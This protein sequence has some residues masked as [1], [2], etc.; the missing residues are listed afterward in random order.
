MRDKLI[1]TIDCQCI[2]CQIIRTEGKKITSCSKSFR[3]KR[4]RWHFY[5]HPVFDLFVECLTG[6]AEITFCRFKMNK[7]SLKFINGRNH[8]E[9]DLYIAVCRSSQDSTQLTFKSIRLIKK[10]TDSSPS[11]EWVF[12]TKSATN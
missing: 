10:I 1:A 7:R 8:R 9:H 6:S 4:S 11:K 5:H 3:M 2:L 12:L